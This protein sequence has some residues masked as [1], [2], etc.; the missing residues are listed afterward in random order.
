MWH[1]QRPKNHL[2]TRVCP[3]LMLPSE[4]ALA[5]S[6]G[7][8]GPQAENPRSRNWCHQAHAAPSG[9][10]QKNSESG[11]MFCESQSFVSYFA[12]SKTFTD[13]FFPVQVLSDE[14]GQ[15]NKIIN[16]ILQFLSLT[17]DFIFICV[18]HSGY[19][20]ESSVECGMCSQSWE[21]QFF[22]EYFIEHP[23]TGIILFSF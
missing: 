5:S 23:F 15:V 14:W 18:P 1:K 11:K 2:L 12:P 9:P 20:A 8:K 10:G 4:A 19:T 6:L 13:F 21:H 7:N 16:S 17:W 22:K 3:P